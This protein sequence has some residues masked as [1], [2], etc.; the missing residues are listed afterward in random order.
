MRIAIFNT[1][2]PYV[3]G[4]A[5]ILVDDLHSNL[6]KRGH[7]VT[8][9]R[10]PFP[11]DYEV[12]LL[13]LVTCVKLLNFN[14]YDRVI[15]IKY[16]TFSVLHRNKTIW[17][18]HQFRQVYDLWNLEFGLKDEDYNRAIRTVVTTIDNNDISNSSKI[19]TISDETMKRLEEHNNIKSEV[20]YPPVSN[21]EALYYENIGDYLF[22]P[23]RITELKRQLL[24]IQAMA[25]TKTDVKLVI[26]GICE[27]ND[28]LAEIENAMR[29]PKISKSVK[30]INSWITEEE[31]CKYMANSLGCIFIPH[32][33]DYGYITLE[34]FL[35]KKSVITCKDSGGPT[36]FV[37]DEITGFVVDSNPKSIAEAMD[38]LY[39]NKKM[40]K[41]MGQNGYKKI[42]ELNITWDETIRRLLICE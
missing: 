18:C 5:E 19:F 16:P 6:V 14:D 9:F 35:C 26:T 28:Y 3:R 27:N 30:F 42:H 10:V 41:K 4:G 39:N 15:C 7:S 36:Y 13:E 21:E 1:M 25:Y 2:T 24:A 32:N 12:K 11:N 29:N 38:R 22:Y 33:E 34:A 20:L 31:K 40:A 37:D 17:M 23:S 8:L